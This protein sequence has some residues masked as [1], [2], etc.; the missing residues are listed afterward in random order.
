[1]IVRA[2]HAEFWVA[3]LI[4]LALAIAIIRLFLW[5]RG[6]GRGRLALL[7]ALQLAAGVLLYFTL[8]P[9]TVATRAGTL[10]VATGRGGSAD[11]ALP[12]ADGSGQAMREPDLATALRRRPGTAA[13]RITGDGLVPRDQAPLDVR[14]TF[15]PPSPPIGLTALAL[16]G[17]VAPGATFAVG[18]QIGAL[19]GGT[20]ELADPAGMIVDRA[21]VAA[22]Q[23]FTLSASTRAP[24]LALFDLRLRD[25]QG[26]LIERIAVAIETRAQVPPRIVVLAGAPGAETKY[27]RRWAVDNGV[28]LTLDVD[29]GG[30]LRLGDPPV[31]LTRAALDDIDLL[32]VDDRRW[33]GL[34]AGTRAAIAAAVDDG[35]GLLLRPTGSLS[36]AT[37]QS[38]AALGV[39]T[40]GGEAS[41]PSRVGG[42]TT[43]ALAR[44]D[45]AHTGPRSI[46]I[47]RDT[48]GNALA[49]WRPRRRGSV[50]I[51]ALTG[52]Y[53]LVLAG[54]PERYGELWS[55]LFSA[56]ARAGDDSRIKVTGIARAEARMSLCGVI[57]AARVIGP[58]ESDREVL[59]DPA[60]GDRACA[61]YWPDASGWHLAR[62]GK[63]RETPFY[64]HTQSAAPSLTRSSRREATLD[65]VDR[66][67][68][69]VPR[70]PRVPGSP[71]PW[72]VALL[73]VLAALWWLERHRRAPPEAE[74]Q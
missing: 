19:A 45:I 21:R 56:I 23:H 65:I 49:S 71:W 31:P 53:A 51:L 34:A 63:G 62:D 37:R 12:E 66:S 44:R 39:A 57:G 15:D 59:V 72:F 73:V 74:P 58:D 17:P 7:V 13:I 32:V 2:I 3:V 68:S 40:S 25:R 5:Q 10:V 26:R 61:A 29:V 9:P 6:A 48:S 70:P 33:E 8:F 1:M 67:G 46:V 47:L 41:L 38:W 30:G 27:L 28:D 4:V 42:D 43:P 55:E 50:G 64:V 60:T 11:V 52:S 54:Q 35:L 14:V 16:P 22:A 36:P 24:G 20:A 18:G 69:G